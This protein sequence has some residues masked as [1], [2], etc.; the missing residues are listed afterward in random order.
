MKL[1]VLKIFPNLGFWYWVV[2]LVLWKLTLSLSRSVY[3]DLHFLL[4]NKIRCSF[5]TE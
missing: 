3:F 4:P 1:L 2:I 5:F